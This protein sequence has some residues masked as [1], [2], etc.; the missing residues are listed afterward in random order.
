[1][2][3]CKNSKMLCI[4]SCLFHFGECMMRRNF[5]TIYM[6]VVS[7]VVLLDGLDSIVYFRSIALIRCIT[8]LF[9]DLYKEYIRN[10][11]PNATAPPKL[12]RNRRKKI[13]HEPIRSDQI[14]SNENIYV[15]THFSFIPP[16]QMA[17]EVPNGMTMVSYVNL[18]IMPLFAVISAMK[19]DIIKPIIAIAIEAMNTVSIMINGTNSSLLF[20]STTINT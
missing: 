12:R 6:S 15:V 8:S 11:I 5:D 17:N 20:C 1:M 3:S 10:R 13:K 16:K 9:V 4:R 18:I 2:N 7:I 19:Y 14:R